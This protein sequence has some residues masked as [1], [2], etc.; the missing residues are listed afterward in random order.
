MRIAMVVPGG[1][2]E[3]QEFRV[4][5]VLL[6]LVGRLASRHS[7]HVI[8]MFQG[9]RVSSWKLRG[10]T[11]RNIG[12][13]RAVHRAVAALRAEHRRQPF[14][15][16]H[17][18]W[19]GP[20]GLAAA[21]ASRSLQVPLLVHLT[22]GELVYLPDIQYGQM[23]RWHWRV[24]NPW[25]LRQAARV[26][27]TSESIVALAA[28]AGCAAIRVPLGVELDDWPARAPVRRQIDAPA[29]LVQVA[30]LNRVKDHATTL[31]ALRLLRASGREVE[32]D[33][34]GEDTLHGAVQ[35]RARVL[36][37]ASA[38]R[39]H[40]F[41]TQRQLRPVFEAAHVHVVASLHEAGPAAALEAALIGVPTVGTHVGHV[42]EWQP[43]AALSV[44]VRDSAELARCVASLLADE[45][46]RL[47]IAH[48]AQAR[49]KAEDAA[50][51]AARFEKLYAE[52]RLD[53]R[54]SSSRRRHAP[55][56]ASGH[57]VDESRSSARSA[58][59]VK[60]G[61]TAR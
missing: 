18:L 13:N 17:A 47:R 58:E 30:S 29:R 4:I 36:G 10:A 38:V 12:S 16:V 41:L 56:P 9:P 59:N 25:I 26:T 31:E 34:V 23:R 6:G 40:G 7:V 61:T 52:I 21:I 43:E 24:L 3:S 44:P 33:L 14:D 20:S 54:S 2:D 50:Y 5:P 8:A 32:M 51:T 57:A 49:A 55:G 22:G 37:V 27:A 45:A 28:S 53:C 35:E 19:T 15:V 48:A 46:L 11:V 60:P 1:V 42:A 39:F